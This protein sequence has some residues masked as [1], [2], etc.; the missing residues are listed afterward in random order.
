MEENESQQIQTPP[1]TEKNE[2][3]Q[4]RFKELMES[5]AKHQLYWLITGKRQIADE[6]GQLVRDHEKIVNEAIKKGRYVDHRT[7][8]SFPLD[9]NINTQIE[10]L[11]EFHKYLMRS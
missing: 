4:E 3:D 5:E 11:I 2:N 10:L 8:K 7:G 1:S 6:N 9:W